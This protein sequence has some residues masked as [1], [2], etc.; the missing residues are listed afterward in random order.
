MVRWG[1]Q[2]S[3]AVR[4]AVHH[5]PYDHGRQVTAYTLAH[6][7]RVIERRYVHGKTHT[8]RGLEADKDMTDRDGELV[9]DLENLVLFECVDR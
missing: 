1:P 9:F 3:A 7:A 2:L 8:S 6:T 5:R 4:N